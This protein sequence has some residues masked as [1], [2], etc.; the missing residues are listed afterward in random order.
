MSK[1]TLKFI[2]STKYNAALF[3]AAMNTN[4]VNIT[5]ELQDDVYISI[6]TNVPTE[7]IL[8]LAGWA[9]TTQGFLAGNIIDLDIYA[10]QG[11]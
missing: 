3:N 2:H 8:G 4:R 9:T 7:A 6:I 11:S 5:T 1:H 10:L